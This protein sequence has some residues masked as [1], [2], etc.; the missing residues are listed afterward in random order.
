MQLHA[1]DN[2]AAKLFFRQYAFPAVC[3]A[4]CRRRNGE[5]IMN[6]EKSDRI[7]PD[8]SS[9]KANGLA[10]LPIVVFLFLYLGSGVY[11][12]YVHPTW[13]AAFIMSMCIL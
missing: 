9:K 1:R 13:A 6:T 5:I 3:A 7:P 8:K 4:C 2:S 12:E 10:L 11:Y